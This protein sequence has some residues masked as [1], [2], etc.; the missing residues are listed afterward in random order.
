MPTTEEEGRPAGAVT[1]GH[2][3]D[4]IGDDEA[5]EAADSS[6]HEGQ[7]RIALEQKLARTDFGH[8]ENGRHHIDQPHGSCDPRLRGQLFG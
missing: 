6:A 7:E 5:G 3:T 4:V 1:L 2:V 8:L